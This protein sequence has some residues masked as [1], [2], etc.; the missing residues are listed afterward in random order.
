MRAGM[1]CLVWSLFALGVL[2]MSDVAVAEEPQ[3]VDE[4]YPEKV[5]LRIWDPQ[6]KK[7]RKEREVDARRQEGK[8]GVVFFFISAK[9]AIETVWKGSEIADS[10]GNA[11]VANEKAIITNNGECKVVA[12]K[13][14]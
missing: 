9:Q 3:K 2:A 8:D 12:T 5:S 4:T 11:W 13:K 7:F 10:K 6:G 14:P 1:M